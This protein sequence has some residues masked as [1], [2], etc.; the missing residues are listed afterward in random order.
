MRVDEDADEDADEVEESYISRLRSR[1]DRS[2]V[3]NAARKLWKV[4]I[5]L[6]AE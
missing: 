1:N 6:C 5:V 2:D 4:L 3:R